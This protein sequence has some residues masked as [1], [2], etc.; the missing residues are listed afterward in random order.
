MKIFFF[1][2]LFITSFVDLRPQNEWIKLTSPT[3]LK[4][5]KLF[6]VDSLNCWAAGDSG[7][8]VHTSNGGKDW[9]VQYSGVS[10][11][12][13]DIFFL[14]YDLGWAVSVRLDSVFGSYIIKT[15]NGGEIWEKEFFNIENKFFHTIYFHDS[16]NGWVAGGPSQAFFG[17]TDGGITWNS[18]QF[19]S[20]IFSGLPVQKIVFF[21]KDYGFACGGQHDLIGVIWKTTDSGLNWSSKSM[22][23]EPL[24]EL[25][26]IDSLNLVGIGGDFEYGSA[27]ART[28]DGGAN[29]IYELPGF[30]GTATGL[31][32][33]K[34]NEAWACLGSESKFILSV[35]SGKTWN[36]FNT[37]NNAAIYDLV[38]TDSL[39]GFAVGDS[40]VILKYK[41]IYSSVI[42]DDK[43]AIPS[44]VYLFQNYPNP[45]NP[46]TKISWQSQ[47]D[48]WQSLKV[49]DVLGNEIASLVDEYKPA[50]N[51]EIVFKSSSI[52]NQ[53]SSGIYFY[54]LK[55]GPFVETKKMLL[56]R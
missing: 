50:G 43:T 41:P 21:S 55:A 53:P 30:L 10:N 35:D 51:H 9:T 44:T 6:C 4:I 47:V 31:S 7:L 32:F 36:A 52:I 42:D 20:S 25:F 14:D 45:F 27:V 28:S 37:F 5:E 13:Q 2:I 3:S 16:L 1:F 40:G 23:F 48:C 56:L 26:F 38:F 19:D 11:L 12:I 29:W 33:R 17:T 15:T 24:R 49:Y 39:H 54:Q 34:Q 46:S 18:P 22:G 8:I